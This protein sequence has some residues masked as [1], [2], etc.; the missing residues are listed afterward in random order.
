MEMKNDNGRAQ[1]QQLEQKLT[2][3][4]G[5]GY[6]VQTIFGGLLG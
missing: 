6:H 3:D 4:G 1:A 2:A 5:V